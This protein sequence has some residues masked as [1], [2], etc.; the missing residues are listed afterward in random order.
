MFNWQTGERVS[1]R[2]YRQRRERVRVNGE[3]DD[4]SREC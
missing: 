3:N 1:V 2:V 4:R